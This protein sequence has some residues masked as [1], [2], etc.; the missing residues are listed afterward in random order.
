[1]L[2][3]YPGGYSFKSPFPEHPKILLGLRDLRLQLS[4]IHRHLRHIAKQLDSSTVLYIAS[5]R[6][7]DPWFH[8]LMLRSTGELRL[9]LGSY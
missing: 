8:G 1:M 9:S 2:K 7:G 3:I 6:V 4:M 5:P